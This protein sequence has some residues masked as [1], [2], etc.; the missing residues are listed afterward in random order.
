MSDLVVPQASPETMPAR[1]GRALL[2]MLIGAEVGVA[3]E[4]YVG[5][6]RAM[7]TTATQLEQSRSAA[8]SAFT[9]VGNRIVVPANSPLRERLV[10]E[11][12][13]MKEVAH[14][15]MLPAVVE[16]DPS[17]TVKVMPP[18][19]GRVID[20]KVQLGGRVTKG[21]EL[22]VI[23]SSDL[24]QAYSDI[25]KARS[26]VTLTKKALDRL[27]TLERT[28]G[29]AVKEREQAQND[30][31]QALAELERAELR[32]RAMASR[33]TRRS[34]PGSCQSKRRLPAA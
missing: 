17:R 25:E 33:P 11:E 18:V 22:A 7:P 15:L 23:N 30:H 19:A 31:S 3:G 28:G 27:L 13:L 10:L 26:S 2:L 21:Q 4:R 14:N 8:Q 9:R 6:Q 34:K 24:A 32:L 5:T 20:L 1:L 12:P 29:I 16:A